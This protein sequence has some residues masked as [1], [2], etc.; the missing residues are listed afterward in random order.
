MCPNPESSLPT[1]AEETLTRFSTPEA[2]ARYARSLGSTATHARE[3]RSISRAL[4]AVPAQSLVLDLPCGT[5]RLLP[6][7]V[8]WGFRVTEA[9]SSLH[10]VEH[11]RDLARKQALKTAEAFVVASV[12]ETGFPDASFDA[13]ISNRLFHHFRER[14]VRRKALSELRRISRGPIVVS[15]FSTRSIDAVYFRLRNALRGKAPTDR[16]PISPADFEEDARAVG[17]QVARWIAPRPWVSK[18]CY[19]V[20]LRS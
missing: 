15:F 20:L 7:L 19:A 6:A 1:S 16:I 8:S 2:A 14:E 9:D 18:Q 5:G 11:A 3:L 13:V 4:K 12:F 17:L 10:M